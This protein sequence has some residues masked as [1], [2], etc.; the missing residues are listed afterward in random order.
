MNR[1]LALPQVDESLCTLC[2]LCVQACPC[3]AIELGERGPVFACPDVCFRVRACNCTCLC[4]EVCPT[5]AISCAFEIV[6]GNSQ[7][8]SPL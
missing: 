5:G 8:V 4:E 6:L 3:L 1:A 7:E 2:E